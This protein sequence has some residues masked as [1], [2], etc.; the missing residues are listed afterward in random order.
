MEEDGGEGWVEVE[1]WVEFVYVA[2]KHFLSTPQV[3]KS[4]NPRSMPSVNVFDAR[5]TRL[6][7]EEKK[8]AIAEKEKRAL[9]KFSSLEIFSVFF[10]VLK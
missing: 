3:S 7:T 8:I 6:F 5:S 2:Y 1:E 9:G 4:S 10:R